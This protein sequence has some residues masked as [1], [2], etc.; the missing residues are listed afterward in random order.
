MMN[1]V[2]RVLRVKNTS[3]FSQDFSIIKRASNKARRF[4]H[5]HTLNLYK[6][7]NDFHI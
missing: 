3:T 5:T 7:K 1:H 6:Y 4:Q 2:A